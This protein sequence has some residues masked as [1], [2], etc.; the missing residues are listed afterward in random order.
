MKT[1]PPSIPEISVNQDALREALGGDPIPAPEMKISRA[2]GEYTAPESRPA[3]ATP[4]PLVLK[5]PAPANPAPAI[6]AK[7][8]GTF[9]APSLEPATE[10]AM[11]QARTYLGNLVSA[12]LH[13]DTAINAILP[14]LEA[15]KSDLKKIHGFD[16]KEATDFLKKAKALID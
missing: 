2:S 16:I 3:P 7:L 6:L 9:A 12:I 10:S 15:S 14:T 1:P 5:D 4:A 8:G 13:A 11:H